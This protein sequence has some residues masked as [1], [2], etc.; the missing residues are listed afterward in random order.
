MRTAG[1]A[2]P[3]TRSAVVRM[4]SPLEGEEH[5][6]PSATRC[7]VSVVDE[8]KARART[9]AL[10]AHGLLDSAAAAGLDKSARLAR[11]VAGSR[12]AAIHLLDGQD[13]H[14]IA[15]AGDVSMT[16][17][18]VEASMCLQVVESERSLYLPDATEAPQFEGNPFTTGPQPVRF[19][20]SIPLRV[21]AGVTIGTLCVYD[22][23]RLELDDERLVLLQDIAEQVRDHLDLYHRVKQLGHAATHDPLT[24]LPNRAV[25]SNRLAHAMTR[26]ARRAGEP[27]LAVLDLDGFK[28]INDELGHQAGDDVLVQVAQRLRAA[29]REED[30][31]ARFGGDEFVVLYEELPSEGQDEVLLSLQERL[32]SAL[33]EPLVISGRSVAVA[34]S[35]GF[36]R[37]T[38]GE[39]GYELLGRADVMMYADKAQSAG[40]PAS[41]R[42]SQPD[43]DQTS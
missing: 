33:A 29:V 32:S 2:E 15:A 34:A 11:F 26:R 30:L 7:R 39:L 35:I 10:E 13:Q 19:Y 1:L 8:G 31:V 18:P 6:V 12:F 43:V 4:V 22:V 27:A 41:G 21:Q 37:A 9:A 36:V 16:R 24:G 25:L 38:P 5:R 42:I 40:L 3:L 23:D 17:T 28:A 14:R 20:S